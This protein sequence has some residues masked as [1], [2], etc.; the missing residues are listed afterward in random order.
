MAKKQLTPVTLTLDRI[1]SGGQ[2]IGTLESGKKCLVWGGLPGEA[3][4][5][6]PT[7]SKSSYI[8]GVVTEVLTPSKERI[9]P[10]D[11]DS[12][13]STSPWQIMTME[14]ESHYKS[15]LIEEA[16]E[17]H[18]IVLPNPIET[19]TDDVDYE[20]RNKIEYSF[21]F[22]TNTEKLDLAFFRRGTHGKIAVES[23]SLASPAITGAS[24][25]ILAALNTH[26]VGGRALKTLLIRSDQAGNVAWQL[27]VK[28]EDFAFDKLIA[29]LGDLA[30]SG[31]II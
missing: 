4:V 22:D 30:N 31:E 21:W 1:I 17:L 15:A 7:K 25:Q 10:R 23:T 9:T 19:Y 29:S 8:Q 27:Y 13:L 6:Q 24:Q 12:Y 26:K 2:A 5:V 18:D 14:A 16:F 20:Y 11:Q 28:D 3:V